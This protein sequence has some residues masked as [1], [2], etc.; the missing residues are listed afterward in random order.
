VTSEQA[1]HAL[2]MLRVEKALELI[3]RA[4]NTLAE[5]AQQLSPIQF[6]H[7][8]QLRVMKLHDK[9]HAEWWRTRKLLDDKRI[10]I[11]REPTNDELAAMGGAL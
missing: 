6:G 8:A 9:V 7:P 11:D 5:A 3:E 2:A 1:R 4:Q 10:R